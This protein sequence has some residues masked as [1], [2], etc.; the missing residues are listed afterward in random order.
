MSFLTF[1]ATAKE[2][3]AIIMLVATLVFGAGFY[4]GFKA[5]APSPTKIAA[6]QHTADVAVQGKAT[7]VSQKA[8]EADK[9][10]DAKAE[11]VYRTIVNTKIVTAPCMITADAIRQLNEAGK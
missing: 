3:I 10:S 7:A 1:L 5:F 11:V 6:A 9:K 4:T 8:A 2:K